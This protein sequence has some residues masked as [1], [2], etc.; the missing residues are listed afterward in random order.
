MG[1]LA[2]W[3]AV[4][5]AFVVAVIVVD[6]SALWVLGLLVGVRLIF[7]GVEQIMGSWPGEKRDLDRPSDLKHAA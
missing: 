4:L 1:R 5:L 2:K 3:L 6:V 7:K